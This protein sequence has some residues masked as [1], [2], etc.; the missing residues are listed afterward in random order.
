MDAP[1]YRVLQVAQ[2]S[3]TIQNFA[4]Q[5][6]QFYKKPERPVI[7][8]NVFYEWPLA[9]TSLMD[10]PIPLMLEMETRWRCMSLILMDPQLDVIY[11]CPLH[12]HH[13]W[14]PLF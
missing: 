3:F 11:G 12:G 6:F 14:I 8:E 4:K 7:L 13:L 2:A 5:N 1:F 10:A 9:W